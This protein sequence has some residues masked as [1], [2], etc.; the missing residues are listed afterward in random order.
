MSTPEFFGVFL[1]FVLAAS[2]VLFMVIGYQLAICRR[3]RKMKV[4]LRLAGMLSLSSWA[5]MLS[6]MWHCEHECWSLSERQVPRAEQMASR[7]DTANADVVV[8]TDHGLVILKR[9][10][11]GE[12]CLT[13][14]HASNHKTP[15][16]QAWLT[17]PHSL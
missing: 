13:L 1:S 2:S 9:K 10:T 15:T 12:E 11:D 3:F 4:F 14:T 16:T 6:V 5:V 17:S 7:D 8:E